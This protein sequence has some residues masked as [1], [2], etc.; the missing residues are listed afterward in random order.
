MATSKKKTSRRVNKSTQKPSTE[1]ATKTN[2]KQ[3]DKKS[4]TPDAIPMHGVEDLPDSE[5]TG[6]EP[7]IHKGLAVEKPFCIPVKSDRGHWHC[8]YRIGPGLLKECNR[9]GPFKTKTQCEKTICPCS[10]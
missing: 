8:Y 3:P 10:V 9:I 1:K 7:H 6:S 4:V 2:K 5:N